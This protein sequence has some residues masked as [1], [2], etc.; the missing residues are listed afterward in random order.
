MNSMSYRSTGWS[1][2]RATVPA[3]ILAGTFWFANIRAGA[4]EESGVVPMT[5]VEFENRIR[6]FLLTNPEVILEALQTLEA[7]RTAEEQSEAAQMIGPNTEKLLRNPNSPTSG[8]AAGDVTIVEFFDYNC[9]YCRSVAPTLDEVL[10]ADGALR[11]VFKEFPILGPNSIFAAKAA[12][13]ANRQGRYSEFHR[14]LM[15]LNRNADQATVLAAASSVGLD[16]EKMKAD[17]NE[18]DVEAELENNI[19]LARSLRINGTPGFV[20]GREIIRGAADLETIKALVQRAR[21]KP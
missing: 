2:F 6:E 10:K 4:A 16:I 3:I 14:R 7:R 1:A 19:A 9:P 5:K 11:V 20:I 17:M 8:N 12:L 13:A 18:P 15:S 21:G